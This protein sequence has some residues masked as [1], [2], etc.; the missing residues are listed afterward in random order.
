MR[1]S[2]T[3]WYACLV[4]EF[5]ELEEG[6]ITIADARVRTHYLNHTAVCMGYRVEADGVS[7]AYVTD[8]EPYG[9][10]GGPDAVG[11]G[12]RGGFRDVPAVPQ[13]RELHHQQ[14]EHDDRRHDDHRLENAVTTVRVGPGP[15]P[16]TRNRR[17]PPTHLP[18][19]PVGADPLGADP[20]GHGR[21]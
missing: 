1:F 6:E 5:C 4:C 17:P 16:P 15:G 20:L 19:H 11:R 9:L 8:H 14:G 21:R 10:V 7:V 2:W 3:L 18:P 13:Q 12:L